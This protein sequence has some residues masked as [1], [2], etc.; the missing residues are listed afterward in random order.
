MGHALEFVRADIIARYKAASRAFDV[1]FTLR[2]RR[3]RNEDIRKS[4]ISRQE[5]E[6]ILL[7]KAFCDG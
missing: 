3:A 4:G 7:M 2:Y 6:R 1:F 5:S